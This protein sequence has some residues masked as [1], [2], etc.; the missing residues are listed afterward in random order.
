MADT[1]TDVIPAK[2]GKPVNHSPTDGFASV[3]QHAAAGKAAREKASSQS[4]RVG[5]G[6]AP[7][8]SGRGARGPGHEPRLELVPIRYGRMLASPFTFYRGAAAIMAADLAETPDSGL[9]VQLCGDAHL[10]NFGGF[11]APGPPARLRRQRLRRDPARAVGVG[12]QAARA[13]ASR[14]PA[15]TAD[16][17][18][19]SRRT[20]CSMRRAHYREA[21]RQ[22]AA[23]RQPRRLVRPTRRRRPLDDA[24]PQG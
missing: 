6:G 14:S 1:K 17:S 20:S 15:A 3:A 13:P 9:A 5:A 16:F 21:M 11:A 10:S 7:H 2:A 8:R 22:F 18:R 24:G 4:R 23:M 19:P 12:R